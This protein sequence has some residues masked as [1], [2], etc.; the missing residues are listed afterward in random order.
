M[1]Y[2]WPCTVVNDNDWQLGKDPLDV[3]A[4]VSSGFLY[5]TGEVYV[6]MIS[7]M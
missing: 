6:H 2:N 1:N 5:I 7:V 3:L 4:I